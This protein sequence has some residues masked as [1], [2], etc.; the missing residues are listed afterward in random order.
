[1]GLLSALSGKIWH[2]NTINT[3]IDNDIHNKIMALDNSPEKISLGA[4]FWTSQKMV[5]GMFEPDAGM[6][7]DNIK[8]LTE[9]SMKTVW[10]I[11]MNAC[12]EQVISALG[13]ESKYAQNMVEKVAYVL[14]QPHEEIKEL[15]NLGNS[16][17][18]SDFFLELWEKICTTIG[19]DPKNEASFIAFTTA[20][21]D[22]YDTNMTTAREEF[23]QFLK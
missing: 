6:F 4:C 14:G 15:I 22:I 9:R 10:I 23:K 2:F 3:P 1:M 11:L 16:I 5:L 12:V 7:K 18:M 20:F 19:A 13:H 21:S 8:S 17:E